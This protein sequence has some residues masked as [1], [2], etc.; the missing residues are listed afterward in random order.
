MR[1]KVHSKSEEIDVHLTGFIFFKY[2][3]LTNAVEQDCV[4]GCGQDT[5]RKNAHTCL[6]RSILSYQM[7]ISAT[8]IDIVCCG[9]GSWFG[10]CGVFSREFFKYFL[11]IKSLKSIQTGKLYRTYMNKFRLKR[12]D[13]KAATQKPKE[14]GWVGVGGGDQ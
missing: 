11:G 1:V 2:W 14:G 10:I 3:I 13:R 4:A 7:Q 6:K 12:R 8:V 9:H 5:E